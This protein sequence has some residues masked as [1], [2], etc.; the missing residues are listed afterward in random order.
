MDLAKLV[1]R[2]GWHVRRGCPVQ[3]A[4]A[5]PANVGLQ[6]LCLWD[7]TGDNPVPV[8]AWPAEGSQVNVTWVIGSMQPNEMRVYVLRA[9]D[10]AEP[11][12][13]QGVELVQKGPGTLDVSVGGEYLTTYHFGDVIRPYL[14]P[15]YAHGG[16]GVT[17]NWPMVEGILGED[18]DHP[19]H[20]GIYTA[21]GEV[22]GVD[23]WGDGA[24]HGWIV[25]REFT[26][27]FGGPAAAGFTEE[28]EWTDPDR[29]T[30]MTETRRMLFFLTP[31]HARVFDYE[32]VFHASAGQVTMG[33]T[34]EGGL[35]SVR[36]AS[37]MDVDAPGGGGRIENGYGAV[38][39]A[40]T[41]GKQAP[42]C[43]YSGPRAG[44]WRG[45]ALMDHPDNPRYPT[46]WHV[47]NYGL[48]TANP[49]GLHDF[50]GDPGRRWDLV[51]PAGESVGWRYRVLIHDGDAR[52]AQVA[53]H[54]HNLVNP[55]QVE[56]VIA[57]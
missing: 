7:L 19:H 21:Q 50:T 31:A 37:S 26:R 24:R 49:I 36:V 30:I 39:E 35:L 11:A 57:Q 3:A 47:R 33:D 18:H 27:M 16:M 14:Y 2:S 22:N 48:M 23:N 17:R 42:W 20:K 25:H 32:T 44:E 45:I 1:V 8:Q 4:V 28:L 29:K 10:G 38:S 51:I 54:W 43:D 55:P 34:K 56:V 5:L 15:V 12:P 52:Q 9:G 53:E 6:Q 13:T 40:E 41:W 46:H